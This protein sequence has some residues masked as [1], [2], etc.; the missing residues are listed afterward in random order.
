MFSVVRETQCTECGADLF[1]GGLLRL[2]GEKALC[3]GCADLEPFGILA[4]RRRRR[5]RAGQ[6]ISTLPPVVVR[7]SRARKRYERQGILVEPE[8]VVRA[9]QESSADLEVPRSEQRAS[10]PND[11][12]S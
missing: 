9:E 2:E 8:A 1:K 6:Q 4:Q 11:A 5:R 3:T 10:R 7:S 12:T